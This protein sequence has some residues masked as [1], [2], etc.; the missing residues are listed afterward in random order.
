[1]DEGYVP[2]FSMCIDIR[3]ELVLGLEGPHAPFRV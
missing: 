2:C 1:M 3:R